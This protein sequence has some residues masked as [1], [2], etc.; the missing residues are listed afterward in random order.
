MYGAKRHLPLAALAADRPKGTIGYT[1]PITEIAWA[2]LAKLWDEP[3]TVS[4]N[5]AREF[6]SEIAL[7]ASIGWIS[8]VTW[9]G[10]GFSRLWRLTGRG[11]TALNTRGA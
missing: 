11:L 6:A 8:T 3:F 7:L 1:G 9:D 10:C 5:F 2:V 4:S